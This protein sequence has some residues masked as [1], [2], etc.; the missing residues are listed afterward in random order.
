MC[1][2]NVSFLLSG[3]KSPLSMFISANE[4][5]VALERIHSMPVIR[6]GQSYRD[7]LSQLSYLTF[8]QTMET[9]NDRKAIFGEECRL[10]RRSEAGQLLQSFR[11]HTMSTSESGPNWSPDVSECSLKAD[12][13]SGSSSDDQTLNSPPS[14]V[15]SF[16]EVGGYIEVI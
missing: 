12:T 3:T 16:R 9:E 11:Q 7:M 14:S 8:L 4:T 13:S 5:S 2:D 15:E 1:Q 6:C 10:P